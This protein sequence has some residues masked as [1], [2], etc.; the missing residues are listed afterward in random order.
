MD[1]TSQLRSQLLQQELHL[2]SQVL[3]KPAAELLGPHSAMTMM[4]QQTLLSID[5]PL[6]R[7]VAGVTV[8][9]VDGEFIVNPTAE[10]EASSVLDLMMAGTSDAILMIEGFCSF[11][12][13]EQ[14]MEVGM[15][16]LCLQ[17]CK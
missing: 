14:L 12:T 1:S 3:C 2:Q 11:L 17:P 5:I 8:G 6:A 15:L 9:L 13:E 16:C 4:Q 10:Q 7:S